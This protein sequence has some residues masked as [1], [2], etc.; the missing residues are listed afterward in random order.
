MIANFDGEVRRYLYDTCLPFHEF[1]L[2][3]GTAGADPGES[4]EEPT[5]R[6]ELVK[7]FLAA[8]P[9]LCSGKAAKAAIPQHQVAH[10]RSSTWNSSSPLI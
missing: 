5:G 8:Y 7:A 6:R 3:A 4:C 2:P 9:T 1:I 10:C